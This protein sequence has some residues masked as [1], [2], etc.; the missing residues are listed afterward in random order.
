MSTPSYHQQE[1]FKL[2]NQKLKEIEEMGID[3]FPPKFTPTEKA[4]SLIKKYEGQE[5]GHSEDG[6]NGSTDSVCVAGRLVLFRAMGKNA[7]AQIQD[8]TGRIQ[9][10]FNRDLTEVTGFDRETNES[11]PI[12]FIEKKIDLGD[13][14]GIEGHLFRT[15][16]NELTIYAKKV[17]L[18]CKTV[19]SLP[20]KHSG[21]SDKGVRYRKRYL[22]LISNQEVKK[23]FEIRSKIMKVIRSYFEDAGFLEVET[24]VLQNI[25]G[26]AE[27]R[28][29]KTH[30]NALD[31]EMFLRISLEIPLKKLIVGG[32]D[33]VFEIGKVFRNEGIDKTHNPEFTE[34]EAYAS[35]WDYNDMMTFIENLCEK[36]ALDLFGTTKLEF[37]KE[38]DEQPTVID[39]KA[40]WKRMS[41]IESIKTYGDIDIYAHSDDELRSILKEKGED[42]PKDIDQAPRGKLIAML[43]EAFVEEHLIQPHHITDHPIE[44]TPLC[45]LHRDPKLRK[46]RIVE[47]FES[48]IFANELANSY[49][50]LNDPVL[51]RTLLEDQN[52]KR[53]TG[54]D[55]AHP[56]DEDFIEA[57]CQ[58]M[59]PCCGVGMG[60][61]R[62]VM[63]LTRQISIRD[64]L[65]FPLM[66]FDD[67]PAKPPTKESLNKEQP[68]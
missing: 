38:G 28:P 37:L 66:R 20:D 18:L 55:E 31:Q 12:K 59:P 62:L 53:E 58:G 13:I 16:K 42:D 45:K 64:V 60:I 1:D 34:I 32:F 23:T 54:D 19:L 2:R 5:V 67:K 14:I 48:F 7:F 56:L 68:V 50:E 61:D 49:T 11:K 33:K 46:E 4:E 35:Y 26:G 36:I 8:D 9:V 10:M 65:F 15:Q 52:K 6:A 21:L 43:F 24:P 41:M 63:L 30:L 17:T 47:R 44:T 3:P 27:A 51:Q 57:I 25:Y 22:D 39:I 29:F 40:P